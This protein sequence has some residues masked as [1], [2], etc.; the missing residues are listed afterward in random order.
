MGCAVGRQ[1]SQAVSPAAIVPSLSSLTPRLSY[2]ATGKTDELQFGDAE[3][4]GWDAY[5]DDLFERVDRKMLDDDK[6]KYQGGL[7]CA[8][9]A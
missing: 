5:F 1:A 8:W 4:A 2:D 9:S 6:E 3:E 7:C